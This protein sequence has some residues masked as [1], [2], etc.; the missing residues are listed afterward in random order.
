MSSDNQLASS[1]EVERCVNCR[2]RLDIAWM[3]KIVCLAY[4]E[5][6][7]PTKDGECGEFEHKLNET[8]IS[9]RDDRDACE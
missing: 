1:E 8:P 4:L 5:V 3:E 9:S 6:R 7:H 2:H